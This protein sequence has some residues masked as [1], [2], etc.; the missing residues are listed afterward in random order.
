MEVSDFC[1]VAKDFA[2]VV[3]GQGE[4]LSPYLQGHIV[5]LNHFRKVVNVGHLRGNHLLYHMTDM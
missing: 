4:D 3:L 2:E 1:D 5:P